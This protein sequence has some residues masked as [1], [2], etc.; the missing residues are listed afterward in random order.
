[1]RNRVFV[2]LDTCMS[3]ECISAGYLADDSGAWIV[4][5][6]DA[7][8][9]YTYDF[10]LQSNHPDKDICSLVRLAANMVE[11]MRHEDAN[12]DIESIS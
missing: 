1:M 11:F 7:T 6:L 4:L 3:T 8:M 5:T 2:K 10:E 9:G 12:V